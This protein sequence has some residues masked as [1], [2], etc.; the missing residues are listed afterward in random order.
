[1]V[2]LQDIASQRQLA[3]ATS[4]VHA[5]IYYCYQMFNVLTRVRTQLPC[6]GTEI[7]TTQMMGLLTEV[8]RFLNTETKKPFIVCGDFN[9]LPSA[10]VLHSFLTSGH[11]PERWDKFSSKLLPLI[12]AYGLTGKEPAFTFAAQGDTPRTLDYIYHSAASLAAVEV[13]DTFIDHKEIANG[14]P[15]PRY[16]SDHICLCARFAPTANAS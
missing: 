11:L 4:H 3:V 6:E 16:P 9:A 7:Q 2:L 13:L 8:G 14:L 10:S 1:M 15:A 5:S 12:S